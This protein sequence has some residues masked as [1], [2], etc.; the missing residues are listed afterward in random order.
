MAIVTN[1]ICDVT[2]KTSNNKKDFVTVKIS[3]LNHS[4]TQSYNATFTIEK[5]VHIDTARKLN[6]V[7]LTGSEVDKAPPELT[8]EGKLRVMLED[9]VQDIV[10]GSLENHTHG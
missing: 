5:L 6:L 3:A 1:Y 9:F 7:N 2:G 10:D 4:S 8:F